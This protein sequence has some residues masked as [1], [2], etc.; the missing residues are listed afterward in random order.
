MLARAKVGAKPDIDKPAIEK[1]TKYELVVRPNLEQ[2]RE[3]VQT[4]Y[5]DYSICDQLNVSIDS[6]CRWKKEHTDLS[7]CYTRAHTERNNLVMNKM[8][9]RATSEKAIL[10]K[11][12]VLKDGQIVDIVEEVYAPADV[13]AA[14]LFL[15]NNDPNYKSAKMADISINNSPMIPPDQ[16]Q[17]EIDKLI[18][19]REHLQLKLSAVDIQPE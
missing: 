12:K 6:W 1:L 2:I 16:L 17:K 15:R 8:F 3:W 9:Q 13:N 7:D 11:Q 14:D 19:E 18:S 4:G 10:R 5:T